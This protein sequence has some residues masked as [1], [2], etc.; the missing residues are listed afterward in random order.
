MTTFSPS[1]VGSVAT[2]MSS[3][4][5]TAEDDSVMRPSC[6]LRRSA[7]SSFAR[8]F[9]RVVT[10]AAIFFGTRCTSRSTPS[11]RNRTTSASS[12]ASK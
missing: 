5:P 1:T 3:M 11:T 6:G 10:P 4:R 7:M 12:W 8:T 9:R 2:R